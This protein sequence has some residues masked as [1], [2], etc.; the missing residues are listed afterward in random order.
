MAWLG[1]FYLQWFARSCNLSCLDPFHS[2]LL[3]SEERGKTFVLSR[4]RT[5]VLWLHKQPLKPLE[6]GSSGILGECMQGR[7]Q[8]NWRICQWPLK[9]SQNKPSL[10]I[11]QWTEAFNADCLKLEK[12][13]MSFWK[14]RQRKK[15]FWRYRLLS[16]FCFQCF[17]K[18]KIRAS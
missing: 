3:I 10:E 12:R 15:A 6:H 11:E 17:S 16:F 18:K 8:T 7:F 1:F 13:T 14:P 5:Q 2:Y 4:N 9:N